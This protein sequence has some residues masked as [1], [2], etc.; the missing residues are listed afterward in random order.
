LW[1]GIDKSKYI[2]YTV[3]DDEN[4]QL[5]DSIARTEKENN[6]MKELTGRQN[7]VFSLLIA[8]KTY[9]QIANELS[10]SKN[11]VDSHLRRIYRKFDAHSAVEAFRRA[12]RLGMLPSST[13]D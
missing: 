2:C 13:P 1:K 7:Q 6:T 5:A 11:T 12:C 10:I 8:G 9:K 3:A 4:W